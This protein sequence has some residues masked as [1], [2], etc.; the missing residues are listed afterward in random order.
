MTFQP[1][2]VVPLLGLSATIAAFFIARRFRALP[3]RT[4]LTIRIAAAAP[5]IASGTLHL[6][7]P[8][9]FVPLI[10][11]PFPPEAWLITATG[12]P[13]LLGAAGLLLPGT[14]QTAAAALAIFMVAIFP[15]NIHVAGRTIGGLPM[16][17]VPVRT[18]M[19]AAYILLLLVAGWGV[20]VWRSHTSVT[21]KA[22]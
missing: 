22:L 19:Q 1:R 6:L 14:R 18:A 3:P 16:P 8:Q 21:S 9:V 20:P 4:A 15:A 7:R 10:P 2:Y 5:L 13:E 17:G 12:I 11:P